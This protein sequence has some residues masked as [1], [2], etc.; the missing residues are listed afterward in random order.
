VI[1]LCLKSSQDQHIL[2][3]WTSFFY[4]LHYYVNEN[5]PFY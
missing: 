5:M 1:V 4:E 2:Y 3:D